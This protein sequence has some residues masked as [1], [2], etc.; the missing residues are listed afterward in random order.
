MR[1]LRRFADFPSEPGKHQPEF[2]AH[3]ESCSIVKGGIPAGSVADPLHRHPFDQFYYVLS[4]T[5]GVQLGPQ[6]IAAGPDTLVRIPARQPHF[7][8]NDGSD[9]V[10][11]LEILLP[12]PVPATK[13]KMVAIRELCDDPGEDAPQNCVGA[14]TEDGWVG[15][16]ES[17]PRFQVLANRASGSEH[18]MVS[19]TRLAPQPDEPPVY[20]VHSFDEL[21]FV[22]E[23]TLT[24]D[25][26]GEKIA[27]QR[28]DLVI[29]PGGVPYRV[30]NAETTQE[31]HLTVV[32]PEPNGIPLQRWSPPVEFAAG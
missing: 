30:W 31:R 20:R 3:L 2:M 27:A 8:Y 22:L 11:Q 32:T 25:I 1:Y 13:G 29:I 17:G 6:R 16:G 24:V 12:T 19:L 4:G 21:W 15:L 14:P 18:G 9:E 7:A 26:A 10:V 23:G 28:H 5:A